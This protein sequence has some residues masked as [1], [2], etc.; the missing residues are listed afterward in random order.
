MDPQRLARIL[1][2]A[3]FAADEPLGIDRMLALFPEDEMPARDDVKAA[4]DGLQADYVERAIELRRVASGWR[5]QVRQEFA[6][7]ISGLWRERA[8]RYSRALLETLAIIAYRQPVTRAEIEDIRGVSLSSSIMKTLHEREWIRI[9]GHKELP[10]RPAV[11]ATTKAFLDHFNLASLGELPPIEELRDIVEVHPELDL[12]LGD[13]A[14]PAEG[15]EAAEA[16]AAADRAA[17][18]GT[19]SS[20]GPSGPT[21]H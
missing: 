16:G 5:F 9:A 19:G 10:G 12:T 2:A 4:L 1:E 14:A 6:S 18:D 21:L 13:E 17:E 15:A 8:P 7:A 11:Y 20:S 3:I